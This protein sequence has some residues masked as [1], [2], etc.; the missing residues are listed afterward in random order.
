MKTSRAPINTPAAALVFSAVLTQG[1]IAR[2]DIARRTGLSSAAVT[3]AARPFIDAGYLQ[4][5]PGL[6]VPAGGSGRPAVPLG[7]RADREFFVGVKLTADE[8]IGVLTDLTCRPVASA[9]RPLS[10]TSFEDVVADLGELVGQLRSDSRVCQGR[11]HRVGVAVSGDIDRLTG[12]V[13]YSPF[14]GWRGR[15]LAERLSRAT[16]LQVTLENDVKALAVSEHLFG[17]GVGCPNF[18]LVTVGTGIG[19][20]LVVNGSLVAGARGV[21]GEIG[22]IPVDRDGYDCHCGGAGCVETVASTQALVTASRTAVG[23]PA[24][25]LEEAVVL[26]RCGDPRVLPLFER[27]G[28]AIGRGLA[29]LANLVGPEKIIVSGE[30][31]ADF[32]LLDTTI[33]TTFDRQAFGAAECP[34]ILRPLPFEE[35]AR[36]AAAVAVHDLLNVSGA[37]VSP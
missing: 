2:T 22:H 14:L 32:D 16:G 3:K 6:T 28:R 4:E 5:L 29:S 37:S 19:S 25:S 35:W 9:H 7:I 36:G 34:L 18:A 8:V 17:E 20:A 11:T 23:V 26:A 31:L 12:T 10:S 27:A 33:R 24:L 30:G 15:P 21:A 1:P 13:R